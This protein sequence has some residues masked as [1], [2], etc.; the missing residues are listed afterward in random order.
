MLSDHLAF[1]NVMYKE[2][3]VSQKLY[4]MLKQAG[5]TNRDVQSYTF[6]KQTSCELPEWLVN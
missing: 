1:A 6:S 2:G 3:R 5:V 4:T